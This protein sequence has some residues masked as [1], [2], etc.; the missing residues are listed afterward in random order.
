M[1]NAAP[2]YHKKPN[3]R[4]PRAHSRWGQ[5]RSSVLGSYWNLQWDGGGA[6]TW[7]IIVSQQTT[8]GFISNCTNIHGFTGWGVGR[9]STNQSS[10]SSSSSSFLLVPRG[11][12]SSSSSSSVRQI[13]LIIVYHLPFSVSSLCVS[14]WLIDILLYLRLGKTRKWWNH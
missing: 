6:A 4:R 11:A 5:M 9:Q 14:I 7:A 13:K 12:S 3:V 8:H 2:K 1:T 10:P